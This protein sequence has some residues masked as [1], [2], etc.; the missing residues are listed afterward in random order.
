MLNLVF[1]PNSRN[2][3]PIRE[4]LL[5]ILSVKCIKSFHI[6]VKHSSSQHQLHLTL[7]HFIYSFTH[8]LTHSFVQR[9]NSFFQATFKMQFTTTALTAI[10]ATL[11]AAQTLNIP[12]RVG[13]IVSLSAP[14][15]ISG[16]RDMGNKEY[17][18]GRACDSD[19]DTGSDSAVFIL[20][21]GATLANVIIGANQLEGVHCEGACT[22][23]N[24]WFRDV[25]EGIS[26]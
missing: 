12:T 21:D 5:R 24:V 13:S 11:T 4:I 3:F 10:L 19:A 2:I 25:C 1:F 18:R 22:L 8:S 6:A 16:T 17:D 9:I 14:S 26:L 7:T 15:S 20:K 23:T